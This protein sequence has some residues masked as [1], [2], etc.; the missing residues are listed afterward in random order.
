MNILF[1]NDIPFNPV[2]GG[3]ER[4]TNILTIELLRRGH[5][6]Y[7][8]CEKV[9][10]YDSQILKYKYPAPLYQL[11]QVGQFSNITNKLFYRNFIINNRIDLVINQRGHAGRY[12]DLLPIT[13]VK[14]ISVIHSMP[15]AGVLIDLSNIIAYTAPPLKELKR[16]FKRILYPFFVLYWKPRFSMNTAALYRDLA[17]YSNAIVT[18]SNRDADAVKGYLT[19]SY[20]AEI[21]SIPNPNTFSCHSIAL[22]KKAKIV[23]Y[24]GRLTRVD[25]EPLRLLKIWRRVYRRHPDWKLI[26]VGDG[27]EQKRMNSYC[28]RYHLSNVCFEGRQSDVASYYQRAS[29]VCLTSNYE[30][31]GMALTE[32]MQYGCIPMTFNNYGASEEIID[33]DENGCLVPAYNIKIYSERL[34][35]LMSDTSKRVSMSEKAFQKVKDFDVMKIVDKWESLFNKI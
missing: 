2:A 4:V 30:G 20:D 31:W 15:D 26:F 8:L 35:E 25:K 9:E 34:S 7:Y 27:E 12:N 33:D 3:I 23:L 22:E 1:V 21:L 16:V 28:R 5:K 17:K 6:V 14:L 10:P 29:I 19:T 18:L 32:G 11:P 13:D 24:V